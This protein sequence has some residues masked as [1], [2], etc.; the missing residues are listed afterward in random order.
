MIYMYP[1]LFLISCLPFVM[2]LEIVPYVTNIVLKARFIFSD[3]EAGGYAVPPR[4]LGVR[5]GT[6]CIC[7]E[8]GS[9]VRCGLRGMRTGTKDGTEDERESRNYVRSRRG[10]R[11]WDPRLRIQSG[12]RIRE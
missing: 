1:Y 7:R 6:G 12:T 4:L 8:S 11:D 2:C 3:I 9:G 5:R 10:E